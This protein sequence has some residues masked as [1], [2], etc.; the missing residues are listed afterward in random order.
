MTETITQD[1][2]TVRVYSKPDCVQC[3]RTKLYL[4]SKSIDYLEDDIMEPGNLAAAKE[5]GHMAAPV[6]VAGDEHWA[7]FRPDKIDALA[8]RLESEGN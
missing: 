3:V 4:E 5:L 7:G 2:P 8:A 1:A 6:V